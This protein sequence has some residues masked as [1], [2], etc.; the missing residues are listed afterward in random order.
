[1]CLG[2]FLMPWD[3][4][5]QYRLLRSVAP[6]NR[7]PTCISAGCSRSGFLPTLALPET[8]SCLLCPVVP[9]QL[10]HVTSQRAFAFKAVFAGFLEYQ[11][12]LHSLR[13]P[14][15]AP[16]L[17]HLSAA[18]VP[19]PRLLLCLANPIC[20]C[21]FLAFMADCS[22]VYSPSRIFLESPRLPFKQPIDSSEMM[23]RTLYL[24]CLKL[25]SSSSLLSC[26]PRL[27]LYQLVLTQWMNNLTIH[28][29]LHSRSLLTHNC[30][31]PPFGL[32][33]NSTPSLGI[34]SWSYS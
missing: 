6:F 34:L 28:S 1:M 16:I 26:P 29:G 9:S 18:S 30:Y 33:L 10:F 24:I 5:E 19:A 11:T 15:Q 17:C 14:L 27:F 3:I 25:S 13:S 2:Q 32:C 20:C 22:Q 4:S 8:A 12:A 31:L 21:C 7:S 23:C